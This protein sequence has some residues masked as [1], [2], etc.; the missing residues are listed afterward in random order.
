M[1]YLLAA[2]AQRLGAAVIHYDRDYD[3]LVEVMELTS[4]TRLADQPLHYAQVMS[5]IDPAAT[6][7]KDP[8]STLPSDRVKTVVVGIPA[9]NEEQTIAHVVAEAHLALRELD[10][11]GE[12]IVAASGCTDATAKR[13]RNAGAIVVETAV[14]K[15]VA[16]QAIIEATRAD[17]VCTVDG[18]LAYYGEEPLAAELLRPI[19]QGRC[20][21]TIADLPWR[22]IYPRIWLLGFYAPLMG[23]FFPEILAAQGKTPWSGQRAALREYWPDLLPDD[24]TVELALN[25]EWGRRCRCSAV[26]VGDWV[27][28]IR[29]KSGYLRADFEFILAYA[30]EHHRLSV[31]AER[32]RGW[33]ETI[34]RM[35]VTYVHGQTDIVQFERRLMDQA[36]T[37]LP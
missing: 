12:V 5:D 37:T 27:N 34:Y 26:A 15:G 1:D 30:T 36:L 21:A 19:V 33:F 2:A 24:F 16:V 22:P 20:D 14:G 32:Y 25:F 3:A 18:D 17:A 7:E 23:R 4:G 11:E 28:P 35:M 29:P 6:L 10:L 9:H 8:G 31:E 13:A